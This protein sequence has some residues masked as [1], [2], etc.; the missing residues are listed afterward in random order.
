MVWSRWTQLTVRWILAVC[1][2]PMSALAQ[3]TGEVEHQAITAY[4]TPVART[5]GFG[6]QQLQVFYPGGGLAPFVP[7]TATASWD[8]EIQVRARSSNA[9]TYFYRLSAATAITDPA[10]GLAFVS[11]AAGSNATCAPGSSGWSV[12]TAYAATVWNSVALRVSTTAFRP[13]MLRLYRR[14]LGC[15][16]PLQDTLTI[17]PGFDAAPPTGGAATVNG[18]PVAAGATFVTTNGTYTVGWSG[19]DAAGSGVRRFHWRR[20]L[21]GGAFG[22]STTTTTTSTSETVAVGTTACY[23]VEVEDNVGWRV[24]KTTSDLCVQVSA[25]A[26]ITTVAAPTTGGTVAGGG[27]FTPGQSVTVT[28]IPAAGFTF[29][30]WTEGATVVAT[31]A[32]YTFTAAANRTLT[33]NFI[34]RDRL[35]LTTAI[36][37]AS[38]GIAITP[39][40]RVAVQ[41]AAGVPIARSGVTVTASR[42]AGPGTLTG[43]LTA[44]TDATGVAVFPALILTGVGSYTLEFSSPGYTSG[45]SAAFP[46]TPPPAT[47]LGIVTAPSGGTAGS[48]LTPPTVIELRDAVNQPVRQSG[49]AITAAKASGPGNLSATGVTAITD[50]TGRATFATLAVDA[51]GTYAL[52]FS[53]TGLTAVTTTTFVVANAPPIALALVVPVTSAVRGQPITPAPVVELRNAL[54]LPARVAGVSVAVARA[55]GT[56]VLSGSLTAVTDTNGRAIFASLVITGTGSHRLEF[57]STGLTSV[58]TADFVV[59]LPPV[60]QLG[61]ATQPSAVTSEQVIVPPVRVEL[62]DA[63]GARVPQSGATIAITVASGPGTLSGTLSS[64]TDTSGVATFSALTVTGPGVHTLRACNGASLCVTSSSF[65]VASI[66]VPTP[67][68]VAVVSRPAGGVS[69]SVLIPATRV[70]LRDSL[71]R[72]VPRAGIGVEVVLE[73]GGGALSGG[74]SVATDSTGVA[75]FSTLTITGSGAQR[76]RFAATGLRADTAT[77]VIALPPPARLRIARQPVT[78]LRDSAVSPSVQVQLVDSRGA[79]VLQAGVRIAARVLTG[80]GTLSGTLES[81]TNTAGLADFANLRVAGEGEHAL[82]FTSAGLDSATTAT[83]VV[84]PRL[85]IMSALPFGTVGVPYDATLTAMGG[86][87]TYAWTLVRGT[88]PRGLSLTSDGRVV[89]TPLEGGSDTVTVRVTSG[90]ET[91]TASLAVQVTGWGLVRVVIHGAAGSVR[92]AGADAI[93]CA[94][95]DATGAT[96]DIPL[97]GPSVFVGAGTDSS[98]FVGWEE[99]CSGRASCTLSVPPTREV[100]AVFVAIPV[101][102]AATAAQDLLRGTG[103]TTEQRAALDAAGNGDGVFNLGDLLAHL[104]RTGQVISPAIMREIAG[105]PTPLARPIGTARLPHTSSATPSERP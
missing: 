48:P 24:A 91:D 16:D 27:S 13:A 72:A 46:V 71:D 51:G 94:A 100:R 69:G 56:G 52:R 22:V 88:F 7:S 20:S 6:T 58:S 85:S 3:I 82:I 105:A 32:A 44:V 10:S 18:T 102:A 70:A 9:S 83:Y 5:T 96:C 87:A 66:P 15:A 2:V 26:V 89:G 54:G 50:S 98:G 75:T 104:D 11:P 35:A 34:A 8:Y 93:V 12:N 64:A 42:F 23:I 47:A 68:R 73:S 49:I 81:V 84:R 36:T 92:R 86:I 1:A 76:L 41:T 60:T 14:G 55:V 43:T 95:A 30:N 25:P 33:A 19:T 31:T 45:Q 57:S 103:L 40:P 74:V 99:Q 17:A 21:N 37:G 39:A 4:G 53:A 90:V 79:D 28:A 65:T 61:F 59:S 77:Y 63:G 62:R 38:S 78:V 29:G 101:I 67:V 80:G 97:G